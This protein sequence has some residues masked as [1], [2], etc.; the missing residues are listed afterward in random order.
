MSRA[1]WGGRGAAFHSGGRGKSQNRQLGPAAGDAR[2]AQAAQMAADGSRDAPLRCRRV[3]RSWAGSL[4]SGSQRASDRSPPHNMFHALYSW[5]TPDRFQGSSL[6]CARPHSAR[7]GGTA[8]FT[9]SERA[10]ATFPKIL[11]RCSS[12]RRHQK[13]LIRMATLGP[14]HPVLFRAPFLLSPPAHTASAPEILVAIS[15][16]HGVRLELPGM[17][18][19]LW[20]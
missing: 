9:A 14:P 19:A 2:G 5:R 8:M 18:R 10:V 7:T 6:C 1:V 16:R 12:H 17:G 11:W 3:A 15:S 4:P 13:R 20:A